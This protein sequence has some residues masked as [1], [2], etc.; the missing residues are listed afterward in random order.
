ANR[1]PSSAWEGIAAGLSGMQIRLAQRFF[2]PPSPLPPP[3]GIRSFH[4]SAGNQ[5]FV[6]LPADS[7]AAAAQ[8]ADRTQ[9]VERL[10]AA[11]DNPCGQ[12]ALQKAKQTLGR[13]PAKGALPRNRKSTARWNQRGNRRNRP[14]L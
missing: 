12:Q 4:I 2:D 9:A 10:L 6:E 5:S 13:P 8:I 14:G 7:T 11:S 3:P 1:I